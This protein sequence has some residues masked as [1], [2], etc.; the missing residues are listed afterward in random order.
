MVAR[1][2]GEEVDASAIPLVDDGRVHRVEF[3]L[4]ERST[5]APGLAVRSARF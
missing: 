1:L 4:A 2:D 5:S 3:T